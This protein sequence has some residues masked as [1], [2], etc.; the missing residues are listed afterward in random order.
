MKL[1]L[2]WPKD[3]VLKAFKVRTQTDLLGKWE[4]APLN[5]FGKPPSSIALGTFDKPTPVSY[6]VDATLEDG[7]TVELWGYFQVKKGK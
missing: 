6:R 2:T 3:A 1:A 4:T 5:V 7:Q